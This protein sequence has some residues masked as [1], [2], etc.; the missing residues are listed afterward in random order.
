MNL[1]SF[2]RLISKYSS[3][4]NVIVGKGDGSWN[5]DGEYVPGD[6]V[7]E[8]RECAV[9][10]FDMK[11]VAQLGGAITQSDRQI[12]SLIPFKHGDEIEHQGMKYKIDTSINFNPFADFYRYV[13]K[14]VSSFD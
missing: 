7:P 10:P 5:E 9:I 3:N 11:T 6:M 12:Y 1:Y 2:R 8:V 13:A 14:G 4:V